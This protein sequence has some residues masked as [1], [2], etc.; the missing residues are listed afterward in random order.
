MQL[1]RF[2]LL[3]LLSLPFFAQAQHQTEFSR[4]DSLRGTLNPL[5]TA[6]DVHFYNLHLRVDPEQQTIKGYNEVHYVAQNDFE[7]I[8]LDLFANLTIDSVVFENQRL[9]FEREGN[10]FF[11][12]FPDTQPAGKLGKVTVFYGGKPI[13]AERPP[14]D[15]GF[16]WEKDKKGNH[17]IAVSCEGIGASL[18]WPNKDH[19]TEEPD[20]MAISF[21]VPDPLVAVANGNL[22]HT[23]KLEDGYTRYDWF[24]HYPI[25]NYNV[26]LN[27]AVYEHFSDTYTSQDG[28]K[29]ALDYYVLAYNLERAKKQF[30]QVPP[31]LECFEKLYGKYPFWEDGYALVETPYWGMEHQSAVAYGN[32]YQNNAYGFDFII[33]H[34]SGHEYWG[35]SITETDHAEMWIHESFTT[36]TDALFTECRYGYQTYLDYMADMKTKINNQHTI[37][38]PKGVNYNHWP[39]ADMYYKG[40]WMLHSIRNTIDNEEKWFQLLKNTYQEFKRSHVSTEELT[41]FMDKQSDYNLKPIFDQ[42]L[43]GLQPPQLEYEIKRR[44]NKTTIKYRWVTD[45]AKDFNMPVKL[46]FGEGEYQTI[47][48]ITDQWQEETFKASK[49]EELKFAHELFY[50]EEKMKN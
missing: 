31:M 2:S 43:K 5:R 15:G 41:G 28:E 18:W 36:Y 8:Q 3:L 24:V 7:R 49:D 9:E 4:Q 22:Q 14:W 33:V 19:P 1:F 16:S 20:S 17:W 35:N 11:I 26:T 30:Q 21:E 29:L 40:A 32:N 42:Y 39:D 13:V 12:T 37:L 25:N 27:A 45:Y 50:F 46:K 48:P 34:E 47:Y 38:A 44:R 6:Y 10:A 23:E